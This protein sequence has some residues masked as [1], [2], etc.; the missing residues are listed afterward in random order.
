MIFFRCLS[1]Y[2]AA[3]SDF[4]FMYGISTRILKKHCEV[5]QVSIY[6]PHQCWM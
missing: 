2:L 6:F 3:D 1:F 4:L 5:E